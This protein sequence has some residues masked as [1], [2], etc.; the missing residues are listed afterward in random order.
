VTDPNDSPF[1]IS[2]LRAPIDSPSIQM[3][4]AAAQQLASLAAPPAAASRLGDVAAWAAATQNQIPPRQ[5]VQVRLVIFAGDYGS[6]GCHGDP[7]DIA[8]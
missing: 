4:T 1:N 7:T 6:A 3:A 5:L 2:A 8:Q